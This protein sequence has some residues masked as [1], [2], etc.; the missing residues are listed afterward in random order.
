LRRGLG[1]GI[2][3]GLST[4]LPNPIS[5]ITKPI[6]DF[7]TFLGFLKNLRGFYRNA[8]ALKLATSLETYNIDFAVPVY[9]PVSVY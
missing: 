7:V 8:R 1:T 9:A 3:V 6:R 4:G 2:V 5:K